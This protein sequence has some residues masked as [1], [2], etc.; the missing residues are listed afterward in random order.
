MSKCSQ[1]RK[2]YDAQQ[3]KVVDYFTSDKPPIPVSTKMEYDGF[4]VYATYG[5]G[6]KWWTGWKTYSHLW[7]A[8]RYGMF[9]GKNK[10]TIN[11]VKNIRSGEIVWRSWEDENPY[12]I[13]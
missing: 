4:V 3:G 2:G 1:Y 10:D 5:S 7:S 6:Q 12:R 8:L 9:L 11:Y 13:R